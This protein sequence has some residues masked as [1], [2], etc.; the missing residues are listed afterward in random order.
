MQ[1]NWYE[2]F[3]AFNKISSNKPPIATIDLTIDKA[4]N[5]YLDKVKAELAKGTYNMNYQ[6]LNYI[7]RYFEKD[8]IFNLSDITQLR[9]EE[10]IIYSHSNNKSNAT[11]NK[12]VQLI[13]R[14]MKHCKKLNLFNGE[15][16]EYHKL[17]EIYNEQRYLTLKELDLVNKNIES[18]KFQNQVIILLLMNTGIRRTELTNILIEN[19]DF[20][21]NIIFLSKTKTNKTRNAYFNNELNAAIKQLS[22]SN[23][24][25]LFETKSHEQITADSISSVLK[26]LGKKINIPDLSTHKFRHSYATYLIKSNVNIREVQELMGHTNLNTTMRYLHNDKKDIAN[27]S[28]SFNPLS[29]IT[30]KTLDI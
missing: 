6:H 26:R 4:F 30:K 23:K 3:D 10:Y 15:I 5:I 8:N 1:I 20:K 24:K 27:H 25:Y 11:I 19:I 12:E 29:L 16:F 21:N 22:M 18:L 2:F 17:K 28:N 9:I 7:K 13:R 14:V